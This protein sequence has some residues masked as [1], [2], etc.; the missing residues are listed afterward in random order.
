MATPAVAAQ[1]PAGATAAFP[2]LLTELTAPESGNAAWAKVHLTNATTQWATLMSASSA[3]ATNQTQLLF[4]NLGTN[5]DAGTPTSS[6]TTSSP[7]RRL[8]AAPTATPS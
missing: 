1:V 6:S 4:D 8:R 2:I 7:G 3:R 5:L